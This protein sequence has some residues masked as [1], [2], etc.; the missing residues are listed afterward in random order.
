MSDSIKIIECPR[1]AMQGFPKIIATQDKI[2]Y[3]RTL[4]EVGFDVLDFGSFVSAKAI[5]QMWDTS[6]VCEALEGYSGPTKLLAIVANK[7]GAEEAAQFKQIDYLGYPFSISESF[8]LRNTNSTIEESIVRVQEILDIALKHNK[9]LIIYISMA[10]GNP[11][12]DLWNSEIVKKYVDQ[13]KDLG[14]KI[15]ALSDTIGVATPESIQYL[16]KA[17]IQDFPDL[18]IG[19]HFHSTYD[20]CVEKLDAAYSAGCLRFDGAIKGLGG[21]PMAKDELVGNMATESI[22]QFSIDRKI[23]MNID[24]EKFWKAYKISES[25]FTKQH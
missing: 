24:L 2:E 11:Y 25:I 19:A 8:Q 22:L 6:L 15:M 18:E 17:V 4:L 5:P 20:T 14:V 1:D 3:I 10:F 7:R 12:G 9:E 21:C 23:E 13:L 16:F